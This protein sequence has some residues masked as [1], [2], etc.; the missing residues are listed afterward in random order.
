MTAQL[1]HRRRDP[2]Q[3]SAGIYYQ[4]EAETKEES[5]RLRVKFTQQQINTSPR[6]ALRSPLKLTSCTKKS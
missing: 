3:V 6:E 5:V 4:F 2:R 1:N